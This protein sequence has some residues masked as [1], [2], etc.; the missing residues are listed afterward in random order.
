MA[1]KIIHLLQF[2]IFVFF[3]RIFAELY[4]VKF[5]VSHTSFFIFLVIPFMGGHFI[6]SRYIRINSG[7]AKTGKQTNADR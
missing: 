2:I 3:C 1:N 7:M 6:G 5:G 4:F